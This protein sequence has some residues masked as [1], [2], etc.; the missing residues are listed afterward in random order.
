MSGS[1]QARL[2]INRENFSEQGMNTRW[3]RWGTYA[4]VPVWLAGMVFA[5]CFFQGKNQRVYLAVNQPDKPLR[6]QTNKLTVAHLWD[7][8]CICSRFNAGHVQALIRKY[9][10]Q[11][12]AFVIVPRVPAGKDE[13]SIVAD[14]HRRFGDVRVEPGWYQKLVAYMPAA[15]AA[16]VFD[17]TGRASYTGPYSSDLYC[18]ANSDGFVEKVLDKMLAGKQK[19]EFITPVVSGCFCPSDRSRNQKNI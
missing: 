3:L 13:Q 12:V 6:I 15:P 8:D 2:S 17:Q 9:K 1:M 10:K 5:F 16:A 19:T 18:S 4:L 7:A 11:G 14:V